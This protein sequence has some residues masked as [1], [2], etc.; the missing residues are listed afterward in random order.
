MGLPIQKETGTFKNSLLPADAQAGLVNEIQHKLERAIGEEIQKKPLLY[1]AVSNYSYRGPNV[2]N[3]P[4]DF[5]IKKPEG[6][7]AGI[8]VFHSLPEQLAGAVAFGFQ[9]AFV[10][11][12]QRFRE[13]DR[14]QL[15]YLAH[16]GDGVFHLCTRIGE[17]SHLSERA[18][19]IYDLKPVI[20]IASNTAGI[21]YSKQ[22]RDAKDR[23]SVSS[24][25]NNAEDNLR[26]EKTIKTATEH[27]E[28]VKHG[29][30]LLMEALL[31]PWTRVKDKKLLR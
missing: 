15:L 23:L 25:L 9:E 16:I 5:S 3:T 29:Q 8:D 2:F 26:E 30:A 12:H 6:M 4:F 10:L 11:A 7:E 1:L 21:T 13:G 24:W 28:G 31:Y 14:G 17:F 18:E 20:E 27:L 19:S 22:I